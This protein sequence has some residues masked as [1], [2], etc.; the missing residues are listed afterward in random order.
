MEPALP[1]DFYN[2]KMDRMDPELARAI[3]EAVTSTAPSFGAGSENEPFAC[4]RVSLFLLG[5][6][7]V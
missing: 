6:D 2:H 7:R 4:T 5:R 1:P 3:R